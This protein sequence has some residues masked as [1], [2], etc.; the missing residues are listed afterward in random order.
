MKIT[1]NDVEYEANAED[2]T[3]AN[4]IAVL[5]KGSQSLALLDHMLQCVNAI[6]QMKTV[7]LENLLKESEDVQTA[8][9]N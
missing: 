1:I 7:E 8:V 6:Q 2:E 9:K 5:N 4:I 3:Q